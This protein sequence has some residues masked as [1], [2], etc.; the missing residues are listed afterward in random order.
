M[1]RAIRQ[2]TARVPGSKSVT[3]RAL[4]IAA[5]AD[6]TT[7]LREPLVAADTVAFAEGVASLGLP[8]TRDAGVWTV[9]GDPGGPSSAAATVWCHDS[10]TAARFL[11]A[12]AALGRGEYVVDASAQMRARPMGPLLDALRQLGVGVQAQEGDRLPLVVRGGRVSGG[13][14]RLDAGVS[15]QYLTALCLAAPAMEKGLRIEIE[16]I[17]SVPYVELTLAMMRDFGVDATWEGSTI[18]VPPGTYQAR[19]YRIEADASTASYF[20]AAAAVTGNTVVVPG[21]G[22]RC[23]Q[24]DLRFATEVLASMGCRVEVGADEVAV[25]GPERLRSPGEVV[26]RDISDTM[27]TL[28][29]IA[30]YADAP[31]RITDVANCRVKESDRIDAITTA[32]GVCGITTRTGPD[33]LEIEPGQPH[34]GV[35]ETRA[36]HRIAMS[37]SVTGL[38]AAGIEL[39]DPSCVAKTFPGFHEEFA[40]LRTAWARS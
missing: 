39:D 30:P 35:V 3:A 4:L 40:A 21:L 18:V 36:D 31:V 27:M 10:G 5:L 9:T 15:S 24:G 38:R 16:D 14:V 37:M 20:F 34:G 23:V 1:T 12:L 33:W 8:V 25:T 26:M 22:R 13:T 2:A 29:A 28:A 19:E 32:L 6:G 11:P 17:V 7:R